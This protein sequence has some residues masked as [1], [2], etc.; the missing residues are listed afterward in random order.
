MS[1]TE[2]AAGTLLTVADLCRRWRCKRDTVVR[3]IPKG[4]RALK[5]GGYKFRLEDVED[6]EESRT[7][8]PAKK[9]HRDAMPPRPLKHL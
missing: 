4:L 9:R 5:I 2:A 1:A 7:T 6:F 8:K 3:L